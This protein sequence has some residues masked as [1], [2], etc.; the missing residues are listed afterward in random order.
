MSIHYS[1]YND[2]DKL[3]IIALIKQLY[4]EDNGGEPMTLEKINATIHF[5]NK[6]PQ[7]GQ[8]VSIKDKDVIVGYAILINFWSNEMGGIILHVD[9]LFIKKEYRSQSIGT[10]FIK[11]LIKTKQK[12]YIAIQLEVFPSNMKALE[13]YSKNGFHKTES[14]L[15]RYSLS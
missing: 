5:L 13:F 2:N 10:Q 11:H 15:L 1:P 9:E 14:N 8:I 12:D 6:N 7:N 3:E 4:I